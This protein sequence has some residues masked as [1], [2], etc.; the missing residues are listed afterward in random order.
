M[1]KNT[2]VDYLMKCTGQLAEG[3]AKK[4]REDIY[5]P[6]IENDEHLKQRT[7]EKVTD[8]RPAYQRDYTRIL[9]SSAFR[10]LQGKMQLLSINSS[11]FY[12][13]RLTHSLEVCQIARSIAEDIGYKEDIYV[14]EACSLAHDIGNPPFGH[15][16]EKILNKLVLEKNN[17]VFHNK[18]P[19]EEYSDKETEGFE[20]NAQTLRVLTT[21][22]SKKPDKQGLNLT[23]RTLLGT[24]KY[25]FPVENK[26]SKEKYIYKKDYNLLKKKIDELGI[27]SK[28]ID[29]QIMDLADEIAYAAHDFEDTLNQRIFTIQEFISKFEEHTSKKYDDTT[30]KLIQD[31]LENKIV[32]QALT[33]IKKPFNEQ[34]YTLFTKEIGSL[35][36]KELIKDIDLIA[37]NQIGFKNLQ[38]LSDSIKKVIFECIGQTNE[39]KYY[40]AM[41][42]VIL[43]D[44]FNF[45]FANPEFLPIEYNHSKKNNEFATIRMVC[46]YISGM[47][48]TYAVK[49]HQHF[50]GENYF[51]N[52]GLSKLDFYKKSKLNYKGSKL[53]N[54]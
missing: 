39:V 15:H 6:F 5:E 28:T 30:T 46:D 24:T 53:N 17:I 36:I 19:D 3:V 41:G 32:G 52:Q 26:N 4:I 31:T 44:L 29:M 40:E 43:E 33:N 22:Q 21:L 25:F 51:N 16:G 47:M 12:R 42:T 27:D 1:N 18:W 50:F 8:N 14:V 10:R 2:G 38:P 49:M 54:E 37:P 9:Y 20:G 34:F 7:N 23:Y 48:D 45:F 13:N 11:N 35:I